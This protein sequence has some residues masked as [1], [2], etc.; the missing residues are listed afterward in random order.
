[1]TAETVSRCRLSPRPQRGIVFQVNAADAVKVRPA[2]ISTRFSGDKALNRTRAG[3]VKPCNRVVHG[4]TVV[5]RVFKG[6]KSA[7]VRKPEG[8]SKLMR[9][10]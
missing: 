9:Y 1:M 2:E 10:G 8:V 6:V 5:R 3:P 4:A 7:F